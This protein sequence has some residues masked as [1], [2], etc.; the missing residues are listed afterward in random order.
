MLRQK[1]ESHMPHT[2]A[3]TPREPRATTPPGESVEIVPLGE[4]ACLVRL[5]A[6]SDEATSAR[7]L[8]LFAALDAA[9]PPGV[10]D[11]IPAYAS[12]L[13]RFDPLATTP[14]AIAGTLRAA[15]AQLAPP[16]ASS[17]PRRRL[18][19]VPVIYG[20]ADG[21]D[22]EE[23]ARLAGLSAEE[24]IR[25]HASATYTVAFLGFLAG[26][27]YLS[28]LPVELAAPRLASPRTRVPA[29]SVAIAERQAGIYPVAS[30]GGWRV[31]GRTA[32]RLFAADRDPPA[33]LRP[34]DRVR[35]VPL[36]GTVEGAPVATQRMAP[37]LGRGDRDTSLGGPAPAR[38]HRTGHISTSAAAVDAMPW[39]RVV[40]PGPLT[41]VQDLGRSGYARYGVSVCGA[42]DSDALRCGNLLLGNL[43]GAAALEITL[44]GAAFA[45]LS[46]CAVALTGAECEAHVDGRPLRLGNAAVL[47]PGQTVE[48]GVA[49]A[50]L[51]AYLC[52]AGGVAVPM[53]LGSRATDLR[54]GFGG[55]DGR[56]LRAG[57]VLACG[58]AALPPG[59]L[60]GRRLP[61]DPARLLP[62]DG[63]WTLRVLAGAHSSALEGLFA[64]TYTVDPRSDRMGVRLV[65]Q[66]AGTRRSA[67]LVGDQ[68]LSHGVPPGAVQVPP[69]GQPILLLADAQTTGGYQIQAVVIAADRSRVAQL[70]LG[71]HVRFTL[72]TEEGAVAALRARRRWLEGVARMLTSETTGQGAPDRALLMRGFAEWSDAADATM[73]AGD[74]GDMT[75]EAAATW[76]ANPGAG[77]P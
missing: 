72:S 64:G 66:A 41:T 2:K 77:E 39:L 15:L 36:T 11:L 37:H 31:I 32:L 52:V 10:V 56:A 43:E 33:L 26:F 71:E 3:H 40:R 18:V 21:P 65:W 76:P 58:E 54:A 1:R 25:R 5:S 7:V 55:L 20:G 14:A 68:V 9:P 35:F 73:A 38:Q 63:V 46:A 49:R 19:R 51:R 22:L 6:T 45:A 60:A 67:R 17:L 30:P 24:V 47:L 53:V 12:L 16:T 62:D 23:V 4:C 27:P 48:I 74:G 61:P 28:G 57:D 75:D 70:R 34:G 44:G 42:A 13:V 50:G 69:D 8:A 59:L 29:G